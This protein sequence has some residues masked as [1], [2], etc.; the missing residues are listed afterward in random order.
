MPVKKSVSNPKAELA[1]LVVKATTIQ[2]ISPGMFQA[3]GIVTDMALENAKKESAERGGMNR[4]LIARLQRAHDCDSRDGGRFLAIEPLYGS[5]RWVCEGCNA[6]VQ[7]E[8]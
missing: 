3:L 2:R 8:D 7:L 1:A 4:R 6:T 5:R